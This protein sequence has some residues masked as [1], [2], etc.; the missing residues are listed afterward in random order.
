MTI[1]SI[2]PVLM[3]FLSMCMAFHATSA[4]ALQAGPSGTSST[5]IY[6]TPDGSNFIGPI[7][8]EYS[9]TEGPWTKYVAVQPPGFISNFVF[10]GQT[11][12]VSGTTPWTGWHERILMDDWVFLN[13]QYG[14]WMS[15][16]GPGGEPPGLSIALAADG[17]SFQL[18]F[19][20][21]APNPDLNP[22]PWA[23]V[24]LSINVPLAYTGTADLTETGYP[25]YFAFEA[26]PIASAAGVPE[27]ATMVL[28]GSGL[29]GL[30]GLRRKFEH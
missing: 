30:V 25:A 1:R 22:P 29:L 26:Y 24:I 2:T 6:Y 16:L 19:D 12:Q 21:I 8:V 23:A 14:F 4:V 7:P 9:N 3:L 10:T 15:V 11:L 13:G 28:V 5:P 20:P 18:Q 27:P 17:K